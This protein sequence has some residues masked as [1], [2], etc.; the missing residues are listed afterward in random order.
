MLEK[1]I[2]ETKTISEI[3]SECSSEISTFFRNKQ[4][5][6]PSLDPT[7]QLNQLVL[8]LP[9]RDLIPV[10]AAKTIWPGILT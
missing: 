1:V 2:S 7:M 10:G 6:I 4:K 5:P 8:G 3:K 9:R